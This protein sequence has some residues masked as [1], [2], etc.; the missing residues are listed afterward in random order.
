MRLLVLEDTAF[1]ICDTMLANGDREAAAAAALQLDTYLRPSEAVFLKMA[2]LLPPAPAAGERFARA[3]GLVIAPQHLDE[4]SKTGH[5]DDSLLVGDRAHGWLRSLLEQLYQPQLGDN[6][7]LFPTLTLASYERAVQKAAH[8][9]QL[10]H[11][12]ICPH[13]F[14]HSAASNDRFLGRRSL[15]EVQK[16][17][18]WASTSSVRRYEKAALLL[19]ALKK[20]SPTQQQR[21]KSV[22]K[23][24]PARLLQ[25]FRR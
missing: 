3:W 15:A 10:G 4:R 1:D 23:L 21:A 8:Q 17:G 19:Q 13:V 12:R 7:R 22:A 25:A 6:A 14:R 9:R 16:R 2:N 20:M 18:Q 24:F 5:T 11:M